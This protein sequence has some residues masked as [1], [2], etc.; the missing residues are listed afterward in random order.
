[1]SLVEFW[2][3]F[4][5]GRTTLLRIIGYIVIVIWANG[6]LHF[7]SHKIEIMATTSGL[8]LGLGMRMGLSAAGGGSTG[9]LGSSSSSSSSSSNSSSSGLG[10]AGSGLGLGATM[11]ADGALSNDDFSRLA[12]TVDTKDT[13]DS[14]SNRKKQF[15]ASVPVQDLG[16][17]EK[18][19]KGIGSKLLKKFGFTGRLGANEDGVS[20]PIEVVMRPQA[21]GL[22]FG[23][24]TEAGAM[25]SNKKFEAEWRGTEFTETPKVD[26]GAPGKRKKKTNELEEAAESRN[27]KKSKSGEGRKAGLGMTAAEMYAKFERDEEERAK[28]QKPQMI[29]D[30]RGKDTKMI[31]VTLGVAEEEDET[32]SENI[33]PKL[34]QELLHNVS[35]VTNILEK[36]VSDDYK[37]LSRIKSMLSE[38][39]SEL[40][41]LASQLDIETAKLDRTG[42]IYKILERVAI[43]HEEYVATNESD[44]QSSP[45]PITLESISALLIKLVS[46]YR[47]EVTLYGLLYLLVPLVTPIINNQLSGWIPLEDP[48]KIDDLF[49]FLTPLFNKIEE[50]RESELESVVCNCMRTVTTTCVLPKLR[51][52]L[53]NEW[54][55][56]EPD[57]CLKLIRSI[58]LL[59]SPEDFE[60]TLEMVIFPKLQSAV[61]S[62]NATAA[63]TGLSIFDWISPWL[64]YLPTR[65]N[66]LFPEIRRK[67]AKVLQ[68]SR[69]QPDRDDILS[70]LLLWEPVFDQTSMATLVVDGVVPKLVAFIRTLELGPKSYASSLGA[71]R[72]LMKWS[73][74]VPRQHFAALCVGEFFPKWLTAL[75]TWLCSAT[76][77]EF[78]KVFDWYEIWKGSISE[79]LLKHDYC[80]KYFNDALNLMIVAMD[81][82]DHKVREDNS[83]AASV[84]LQLNPKGL[85]HA[86]NVRVNADTDSYFKVIES[87]KLTERTRQDIADFRKTSSMFDRSARNA[88]GGIASVPFKV[89]VENFAA[90]Y[91]VEFT[92]KFGQGSKTLEGHQLWQ[93][94]RSSCYMDQDVMFVEDI[95]RK[96]WIPVTL[97]DLLARS[98]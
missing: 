87:W 68:S 4:W 50:L 76:A 18:H 61:L 35:L 28:N 56:T 5:L 17:W 16:G 21:Q 90:K 15:V 84:V 8:G 54:D 43:K 37:R 1:M 14:L 63:T 66:A 3:E 97:E 22:G 31:D 29:I 74:L 58:R 19:T 55:A 71:F 82:L 26:K 85:L 33:K 9:G 30:M 94:G 45:S 27:W 57:S 62:W 98:Q 52:E 47:L 46:E 70:Q 79:D 38:S 39:K 40:H 89:V 69:W 32:I 7:H 44:L 10:L 86:A 34:G 59:V 13:D 88:T 96:V 78:P 36:E 24:F 91:G 12:D 80:M 20:R 92:P 83:A 77:S 41:E 64:T 6:P 48:G 53:I 42:R 73:A 2:D 11:D 23:D 95:A 67:Y 25:E 81:Q 51:T 72:S 65:V 60:Q 49:S 75:A 93:F